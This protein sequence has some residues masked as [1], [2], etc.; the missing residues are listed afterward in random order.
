[1][2]YS[3][4]D[5]FPNAIITNKWEIGFCQHGTVVGNEFKSMGFIDAVEDEGNASSINTTPEA[6]NSDILLYVPPCE[7]PTTNTNKLVSSY[8]LHDVIDDDYYMIVDAGVGK[9]QHTGEIEHIELKLVQTEV[10]NG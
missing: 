9:N 7:L 6:L 1:M 3:I 5:A 4:F 8:M 10:V 2:G